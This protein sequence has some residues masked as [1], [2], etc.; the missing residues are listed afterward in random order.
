[1]S[2]SVTFRVA[3][4]GWALLAVGGLGVVGAAALPWFGAK[5][6]A[7]GVSSVSVTGSEVV[8]ALVPLLGV[9]VA[10]V[11]ARALSRGAVARVLGWLTVVASAGM[12]AV[13]AGALGGGE[14]AL[15]RAAAAATGVD[16][17]ASPVRTG[18]GGALAIVA[19]V[20]L[21]LGALARTCAPDTA[22][23]SRYDRAQ[24]GVSAVAR[25]GGSR[26]ATDAVAQW[27]ALT[28]GDEPDGSGR[29]GG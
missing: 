5:V 20:V 13:V 10:S 29:D 19:A 28:R 25:A 11:L 12:V 27:D 18:G 17:L 8:P 6:A 2:A 23:A 14:T 7:P 15:Q 21:L 3:S 24:G 26:A 22:R 1:M 9:V 16:A 4:V